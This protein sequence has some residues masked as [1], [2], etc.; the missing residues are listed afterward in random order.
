MLRPYEVKTLDIIR[1]KYPMASQNEL[2]QRYLG[3]DSKVLNFAYALYQHSWFGAYALIVHLIQLILVAFYL[4]KI[5]FLRFKFGPTIQ[6]AVDGRD[7]DGNP[8]VFLYPPLVFLELRTI[9]IE[10]KLFPFMV[11]KK[12]EAPAP[13]SPYQG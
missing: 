11:I 5:L 9:E 12:P 13:Q 6:F 7:I 2:P 3:S 8:K 4:P 1:N 10:Q